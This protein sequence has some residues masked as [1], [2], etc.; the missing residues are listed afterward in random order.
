MKCLKQQS[1]FTLIELMITVAIIGI[2]VGIAYPS[3]T[4]HV[5]KS[6]RTEAK[7]ILLEVAAAQE[8]F[9]AQQNTYTTDLGTASGLNFLTKYDGNSGTLI[10]SENDYYK[11]TVHTCINPSAELDSCYRLVATANQAT[12]QKS[13]TECGFLEFDGRGRK[14]NTGRDGKMA[15]WN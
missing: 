6:R 13:D 8:S 10:Y 12:S 9:F 1:G 3:Y 7:A 11:V 4:N 14:T 15:C 5:L 2:L